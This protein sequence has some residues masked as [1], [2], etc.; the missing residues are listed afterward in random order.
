METCKIAPTPST[1][2]GGGDDQTALDLGEVKVYRSAVGS[3]LYMASD[4]EDIQWEVSKL[5]RRLKEPRGCD[6]KLLKRVAR[7]LQGTR[8][9]VLPR[10]P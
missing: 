3:L 5:A 6:L 8:E 1:M 2:S 4:R 7:Y 10:P 9:M